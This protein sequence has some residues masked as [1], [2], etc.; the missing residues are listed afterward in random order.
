MYRAILGT[1][2]AVAFVASPAADDACR[3]VVAA[4]VAE[5]KAGAAQWGEREAALARAAAGAACVKVRS[6]DYAGASMAAAAGDGD[7]PASGDAETAATDGLWPFE[8]FERN[9]VPGSPSKK[10]YERRR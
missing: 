4:T 10:P 8:V 7:R 2:A 9:D 6:G 1:L 5:L 3:P